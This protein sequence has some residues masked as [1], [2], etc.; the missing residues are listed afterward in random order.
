MQSLGLDLQSAP[1][2]KYLPPYK[3]SFCCQST[4]TWPQ[5][6]AWTQW[7]KSMMTALLAKRFLKLLEKNFI[8]SVGNAVALHLLFSSG[9]PSSHQTSA[10]SNL[11]CNDARGLWT[12]E[13]LVFSWCW[14][15]GKVIFFPKCWEG[16]K[17]PLV[18]AA[19]EAQHRPLVQEEQFSH[20][21]CV[22]HTNVISWW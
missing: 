5:R 9:L 8:R 2:S 4:C 7:Y 19:A 12:F 1:V 11:C 10:I 14:Q 20:I 22:S 18:G 21:P 15:I 16:G 3:A 13:F 6:W 17:L